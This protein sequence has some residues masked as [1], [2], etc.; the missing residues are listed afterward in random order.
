MTAKDH[1]VVSSECLARIEATRQ[2]FLRALENQPL[3][4]EALMALCGE[5]QTHAKRVLRLM[6]DA[7]LVTRERRGDFPHFRFVYILQP[8]AVK[9]IKKDRLDVWR[10]WRDPK[11]GIAP[12]RLG[13][14]QPVF[15]NSYGRN[16]NE[17]S[18]EPN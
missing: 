15:R 18:R 3:G 10:G 17:N 7:G 14:D 16:G 8:E 6:T 1:S 9:A 2:R 12:P 11:T 4:T 5:N 13:L